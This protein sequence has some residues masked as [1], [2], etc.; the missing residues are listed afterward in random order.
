M[1]KCRFGQKNYKF[2]T[3]IVFYNKFSL[4]SRSFLLYTKKKEVYYGIY[5]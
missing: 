2:Y 5:C 3:V 1:Q 4:D